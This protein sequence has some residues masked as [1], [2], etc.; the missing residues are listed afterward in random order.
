[1]PID[2]MSENLPTIVQNVR[3]FTYNCANCQTI[4]VIV[5]LF[6]LP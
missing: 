5:R 4:Y 3:K 2:K 1:M 6:K